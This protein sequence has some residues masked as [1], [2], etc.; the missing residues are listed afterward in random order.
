MTT[1]P[2]D[3]TGQTQAKT[4][5]EPEAKTPAETA[6]ALFDRLART[7]D[8]DEAAGIV[9]A[10]GRLWLEFGVGHERPLDVTGVAGDAGK[11]IRSRSR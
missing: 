7:Q 4:P 6:A 8:F 1:R 9:S 2:P 11:A 5:A 10:L 3:A